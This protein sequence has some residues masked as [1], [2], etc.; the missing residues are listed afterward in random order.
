M[1]HGN[2]HTVLYKRLIRDVKLPPTDQPLTNQTLVSDCR[3]VPSTDLQN[4]SKLSYEM[5][6]VFERGR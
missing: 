2:I 5:T 6:Q 4:F 1:E 3:V